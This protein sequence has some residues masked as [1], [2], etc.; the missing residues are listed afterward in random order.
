MSERPAPFSG[1]GKQATEQYSNISPFNWMAVSGLNREWA[2]ELAALRGMDGFDR[3]VLSEWEVPVFPITGDDVIAMGVK[4]GP[5]V[6][7]LLSSLKLYWAYNN[8][9][10]TRHD[11]LCRLDK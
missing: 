4:Q 10:P 3:A 9:T 8:Y 1:N 7:K 5:E 2:L 6:G 11:L